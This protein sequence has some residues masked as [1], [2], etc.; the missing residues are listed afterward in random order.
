MLGIVLLLLA[1]WLAISIIGLVIEGLVWLF[2][3]G[4]VLFVLTSVWGW[5]KRN[6]GG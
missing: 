3:I 4:A 2:I 1:I 5:I 6:S